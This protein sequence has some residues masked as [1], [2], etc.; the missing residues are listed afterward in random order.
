MRTL[1]SI[2]LLTS[3]VGAQTLTA[4]DKARAAYDEGRRA[5]K[6]TRYEAALA[7]FER[8][9][10]LDNAPPLLFNM[11]RSCEEM[12]NAKKAAYYYDLYLDRLPDAADRPEVERRVRVM[13]VLLAKQA[14][15]QPPKPEAETET[16]VT[17]ADGP[18]S[19]RPYAYGALAAGGVALVAGVVFGLRAG[20]LETEHQDATNPED[21]ASARDDGESAVD[22]ANVSYAVSGVLLAA[23]AALWFLEPDAPSSVAVTPAGFVWRAR[24]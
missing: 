23:G 18:T 10:L 7:H 5:F 9:Y 22:S 16:Q 14:A 21:A 4:E 6:A 2:A 11:A 3:L 13:K 24:W 8:A 20:E 17:T 19:L 1:L 15:D 12:G